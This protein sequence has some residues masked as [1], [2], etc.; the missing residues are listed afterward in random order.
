MSSFQEKLEQFK[1]RKH[2]P[3]KP[4]DNEIAK[5]SPSSEPSNSV[6]NSVICNWTSTNGDLAVLGLAAKTDK[7][8]QH[9]YHRFYP[10]YIEH[11]RQ[12][13][14]GAMLEIGVENAFSIKMWLDY[15]PRAFIYGI[16]IKCIDEGERYKIFKA[17]QSSIRELE[18]VKLQIEKP[19][20]F[21]ID[22]GS[23]I[24]EHQILTFDYYFDTLLQPGGTYIIEDI[25]TSYWTRHGLYG[26]QTRYGY[27]HARSAVELF[28]NLV[29]D[30]NDE[31][32]HSGN[33][34]AQSRLVQNSVGVS[35]RRWISSITF[36]Q[37][38]IIIVK[39]TE[40]EMR[41]FDGRS[42]RYGNN[43]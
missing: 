11:H 3:G 43:L 42:Y 8:S 15:F 13:T 39:K 20:F 2:E 34:Y 1:K 37:N 10:R 18:S 17:D 21:I 41:T 26:Y 12:I 40:D 25:E 24:P 14:G 23:H 7:I 6:D 35:T 27:H 28:K 30:V 16:D 32:L 22:D 38:C 5:I 36:G 9:G 4:L 33:K 31:Y 29:D 19:L